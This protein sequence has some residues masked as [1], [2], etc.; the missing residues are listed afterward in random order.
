[1]AWLYITEFADFT[2]AG[3]PGGIG[4][5]GHQP[6][7][8]EQAVAIGVNAQSSAFNV[9]TRFVRLHADAICAIE[10]GTNPT[11]VAAGASGTARMAANQTEYHGV[12]KGQSYKV[13]VISST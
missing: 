13:A 6:P 7:L 5:I 3:A 9:N 11:A 1:M 8:A 4:Q 2:P 10:F 12:P